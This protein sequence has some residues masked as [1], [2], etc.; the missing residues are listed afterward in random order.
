[1]QPV[2]VPRDPAEKA[3]QRALMQYNKPQNR[4]LVEKALRKAGREDLI[5]WD[6]DCL[7]PPAGG[8]GY[9]REEPRRGEKPGARGEK[10][11]SRGG[12]PGRSERTGSRSGKA[13]G[14]DR[15]NFRGGQSDRSERAERRGERPIRGERSNRRGANDSP[16][17]GGA[18]RAADGRKGARFDERNP[19]SFDGRSSARFDERNPRGFDERIS[20]APSGTRSPK[21]PPKGGSSGKKHR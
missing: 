9:G 15:Q 11:N 8:H 21:H 5:G 19:R 13:G 16:A 20:R 12:K 14:D 18:S 1:M 7:I 10:P 2:Y 4:A 6:K 3:L 17:R